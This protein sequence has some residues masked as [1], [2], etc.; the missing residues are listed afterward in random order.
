MKL[1]TLA[2]AALIG[3]VVVTGAILAHAILDALCR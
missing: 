1:E 3:W 2:T